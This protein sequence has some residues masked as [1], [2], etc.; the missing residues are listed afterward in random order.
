MSITIKLDAPALRALIAD[1]E[2]FKLELQRAVIAEVVS[3]IVPKD[4]GAAHVQKYV[5]AQIQATLFDI[6]KPSHQNGYKEIWTPKPEIRE[7]LLKAIRDI[8]ADELKKARADANTLIGEL[9]Q[10]AR[11]EVV[12]KLEPWLQDRL[13]DG[14]AR[15][16]NERIEERL[17]AIKAALP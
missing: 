16:L 7:K 10:K 6:Q 17:A 5:D 1:D 14:T 2:N 8:G 12:A 15:I 3:Q 11:D 9:A 13:T 4:I